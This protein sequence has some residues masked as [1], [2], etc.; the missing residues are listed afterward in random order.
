M[1]SASESGSELWLV[2]S[3]RGKRPRLLAGTSV[4]F[5]SSCVSLFVQLCWFHHLEPRW[6]SLLHP[7]T[8]LHAISHASMLVNQPNMWR[9]LRY[10]QVNQQDA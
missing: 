4:V 1:H 7:Y 10:L 9:L 8:A 2:A 5:N 3:N 6:W